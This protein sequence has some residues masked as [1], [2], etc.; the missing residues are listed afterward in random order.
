MV[1]KIKTLLRPFKR[2]AERALLKSITALSPGSEKSGPPKSY[3]ANGSLY[4]QKHSYNSTVEY[5]KYADAMPV[6]GY[7]QLPKTIYKDIHWVFKAAMQVVIPEQYVLLLKGGR[8]TDNSCYVI[9]PDDCVIIDVSREFGKNNDPDRMS[10]FKRFKLPSLRYEKGIVAVVGYTVPENYFHWM[11]NVLPRIAMLQKTGWLQKCDKIVINELNRNYQLETLK[12]LGIPFDKLIYSNNRLHLKAETLVVPS[13]P[14]N[15]DIVP[16]WVL[17]FV[18]GLYPGNNAPVSSKQY[19]Y[20]SR[21]KANTRKI[22]NE[23]EV[24]SLL[25]AYGFTCV[26]LENMSI[27]EQAAVFGNASVIVAPHG[28]SQTNL[29]FCQEGTTVIEIFP[30]N[31]AS[32]IY[33]SMCVQLGLNYYYL[34]DKGLQERTEDYWKYKSEDFS[35]STKELEQTLTMAS[36]QKLI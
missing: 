31:W 35:V 23:K 17:R 14:H 1:S 8:V 20:I 16:E 3:C 18:R 5:F 7:R 19:I 22:I 15:Q 36:V 4:Y 6:T 29:V 13:V 9:A 21:Q 33:W 32:P 11:I 24:I 34:C 10:I 2:L 12:K 28:A 25:T 26:E 30:S 27:E